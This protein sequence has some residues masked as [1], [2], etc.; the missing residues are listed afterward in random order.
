M[1][2]LLKVTLRLQKFVNVAA[3]PNPEPV[4]PTDIGGEIND[5]TVTIDEDTGWSTVVLA[6]SAALDLTPLIAHIT[7]QNFVYLEVPDTV[8]LTINN[9]AQGVVGPRFLS[10]I[11]LTGVNRIVV[12]NDQTPAG[13]A[14]PIEITLRYYVGGRST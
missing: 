1:A 7:T 3:V 8:S 4:A 2:D 14:G 11:V 12:T 9:A 5:F 13:E 10:M 6:A